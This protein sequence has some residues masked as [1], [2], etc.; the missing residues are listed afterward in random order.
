MKRNLKRGGVI[1]FAH[2]LL[3]S[4]MP[5]TVGAAT[6]ATALVSGSQL[7][8]SHN[9]G[10]GRVSSSVARKIRALPDERVE[11]MPIPVLMG[12]SVANLTKN[13]GDPRGGGARTHEG[14][15]IMAPKGAYIVSPTEAVV[16]GVGSG[17]NSGKYV[18]TANPGGERLAYMHLDSIAVKSGDVLKAGDLI[19]TVGNTGNASGGAPHLHFEIRDNGATD[20]Y[21]RLTKTFTLAERVAALGRIAADAGDEEEEAENVVSLYRATLLSARAQGITLSKELNSALGSAAGAGAIVPVGAPSFARD[22]TLGSSG[23]DVTALQTFLIAENIGPAGKA[24]SDAGATGYFGSVTQKAL[25]EFQVARGISPAYGYFGPV[26][27]AR[28]LSVL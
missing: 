5:A 12:I 16:T 10:Y 20:P 22:L 7:I 6:T 18:Y 26:T 8:A 28:I 14:L 25:I 27:R 15:D 4:A 24:L 13:F 11:E 3:F 19:G 9:S 2:A 21:P 23:P 17:E 1:F